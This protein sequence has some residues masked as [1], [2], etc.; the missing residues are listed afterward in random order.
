MHIARRTTRRRPA[1]GALGPLQGD[2]YGMRNAI[3]QHQLPGS[4]PAAIQRAGET[5]DARAPECLALCDQL[6]TESPA[7]G[8]KS[9]KE[10]CFDLCQGGTVADPVTSGRNQARCAGIIHGPDAAL[11]AGDPESAW[12]MCVGDPDSFVASLEASGIPLVNP[13]GSKPWYKKPSTWII[14]AAAV[15]AGAV[16]YYS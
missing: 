1:F 15:A 13:E 10:R 6:T 7:I 5:Y 4:I 3:L 8:E 11:F 12:S 9:A 14:A 2:I 16:V